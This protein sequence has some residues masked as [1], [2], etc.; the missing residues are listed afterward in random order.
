MTA[1]GLS[2]LSADAELI[3]SELGANS[4]EHAEGA[5]I[6][7]TISQHTEPNGQ[8]G[9]LCQVTDTG[10]GQPT[11]Q[12]IREESERGRGL[13]IVAALATRSGVT[14]NPHG[15]TAWFTLTAWPEPTASTRHIGIEPE[16]GA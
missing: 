12:P 3:A 13:R 15:K 4:A 14:T 9:I 11:G 8:K 16:P 2:S 10:P 1:W 5:P 7:L 6:G